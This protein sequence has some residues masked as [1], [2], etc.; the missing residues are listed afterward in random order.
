M[1]TADGS[2]GRRG[3]ATNPREQRYQPQMA[4]RQWCFHVNVFE[5]VR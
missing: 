2:A 5:Q 1:N 3:I 4:L